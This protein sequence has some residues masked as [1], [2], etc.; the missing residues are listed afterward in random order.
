MEVKR[1]GCKRYPA[2]VAESRRRRDKSLRYNSS[3]TS[4]VIAKSGID[5]KIRN[6]DN[7]TL[8]SFRM[9]ASRSL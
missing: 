6:N 2:L 1:I 3:G 9:T 5:G 4:R 7:R 8:G